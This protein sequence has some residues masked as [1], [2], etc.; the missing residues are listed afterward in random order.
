MNLLKDYILSVIF[1]YYRMMKK[2]NKYYQSF[3]EFEL[4]IFY[5]IGVLFI[6]S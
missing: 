6:V 3:L 4:F 5:K 1:L 2:H